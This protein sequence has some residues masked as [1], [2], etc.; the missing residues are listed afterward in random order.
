V[1]IAPAAFGADYGSKFN[2]RELIYSARSW[3]SGSPRAMETSLFECLLKGLCN[4][5][6]CLVQFFKTAGKEKYAVT[7][8]HHNRVRFIPVAYF[9]FR[10]CL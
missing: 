9:D 3:K 7:Q 6:C 5:G 1:D 2:H 10:V 8:E 4:A